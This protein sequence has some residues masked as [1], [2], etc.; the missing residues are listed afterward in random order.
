M[1]FE[2]IRQA[3]VTYLVWMAFLSLGLILAMTRSIPL[4]LAILE[5]ANLNIL[6]VQTEV[7]F[8]L[9]VWPLFIPGMVGHLEGR[10]ERSLNLLCHSLILLLL[11]FPLALMTHLVARTDFQV[12]LAGR[13]LAVAAAL[14]VT[15]I[16]GLAAVRPERV[17]RWYLLGALV[18]TG[19]LPYTSFIMNEAA[20]PPSISVLTWFSP[21]WSASQ[22][23][24]A[25]T[26]PLATSAIFGG[27]G[28]ILVGSSWLARSV[29]SPRPEVPGQ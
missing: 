27:V 23:N 25:A 13:A 6:L 8:L 9:L 26:P 19:A 4:R 1:R 21:M 5:P 24:I 12:L 29:S 22:L 20:G 28:L 7:F 16:F 11:S 3:M 18:L 14:F 2:K 15:G 17:I 10:R